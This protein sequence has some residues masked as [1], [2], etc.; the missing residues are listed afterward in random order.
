MAVGTAW[1][2]SLSMRL[3]RVSVGLALLGEG[4]V[5]C[6]VRRR[7]WRGCRTLFVAVNNIEPN[8]RYA[9]VLELL[10]IFVSVGAI[11]GRLMP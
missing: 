2:L 5:D 8:R 11:P 3:A 7:H 1:T 6:H 9:S 4:N 10:I